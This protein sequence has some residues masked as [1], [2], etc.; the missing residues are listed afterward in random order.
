MV[1]AL[2]ILVHAKVTA[3]RRWL[4]LQHESLEELT[5]MG[6]R[7]CFDLLANTLPMSVEGPTN[8]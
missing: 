7:L 6:Q 2:S 4:H 1:V 8:R 5:D 3:Q